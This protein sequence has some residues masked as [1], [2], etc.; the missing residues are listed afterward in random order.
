MSF[1]QNDITHLTNNTY[2][3]PYL[4]LYSHGVAIVMLTTLGSAIGMT[5]G[6]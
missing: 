1:A 6:I 2:T 3:S 5:N 4:A